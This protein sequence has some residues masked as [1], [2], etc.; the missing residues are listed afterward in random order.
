VVLASAVRA[1]PAYASGAGIPAA[2]SGIGVAAAS[3][4]ALALA[5]SLRLFKQN[6]RLP[7]KQ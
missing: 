4:A 3:I 5:L 6:R 7:L 2:V 1:S